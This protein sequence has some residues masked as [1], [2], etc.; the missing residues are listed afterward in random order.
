MAPVY[1]SRI[2]MTGKDKQTFEKF[3][4]EFNKAFQEYKKSGEVIRLWFPSDMVPERY[5]DVVLDTVHPR[6]IVLIKRNNLEGQGIY[7]FKKPCGKFNQLLNWIDKYC[8]WRQYCEVHRNY[9]ELKLYS[10]DIF[11]KRGLWEPRDEKRK[12]YLCHNPERCDSIKKKLQELRNTGDKVEI[13]IET[14]GDYENLEE[15]IRN[16]TEL[17]GSVLYAL[18]VKVITPGGKVKFSGVI[19]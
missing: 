10:A 19:Y 3:R 15:S 2:T 17:Y 5:Y 7:F 13:Y 16:E 18:H 9:L 8:T 14:I 4:K 1:D 12:E 11:G 6:G